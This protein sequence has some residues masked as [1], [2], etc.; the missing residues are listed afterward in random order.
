M[1]FPLLPIE[2]Q[3]LSQKGFRRFAQGLREGGVGVNGT[4]QV[5][6]HRCHFHCQ[7]AL[8]NEFPGMKP[9]QSDTQNLTGLGVKNDLGQ[10]L[11]SAHRYRST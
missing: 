5:F 4:G 1:N 8:R 7:Y 9:D 3:S 6:R 11:R 2:I 10:S